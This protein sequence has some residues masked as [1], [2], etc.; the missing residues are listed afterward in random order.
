MKPEKIKVNVPDGARYIDN[1]GDYWKI[2]KKQPFFY[3]NKEWIAYILSAKIA[4]LKYQ[5]KPL[6]QWFFNGCNL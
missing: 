6:Q 5:L 2:V 3:R 1:Q 4:K